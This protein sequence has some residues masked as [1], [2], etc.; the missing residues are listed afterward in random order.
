MSIYQKCKPN[1]EP[2]RSMHNYHQIL[3]LLRRYSRLVATIVIVAI[4]G[5]AVEGLGIGLVL[6]L[7][8]DGQQ[9]GELLQN[10]PLMGALSDF[11]GSL[12]LLNRLRFVAVAL[13]GIVVVQALMNYVDNLLVLRLKIRAEQQ[14]KQ[15]AYRQLHRVSIQFINQQ[16]AGDLLATVTRHTQQVSTIVSEVAGAVSNVAILA[17]YGLLMLLIS[18]QMTLV[19]MG[20]LLV[21]SLLSPKGTAERLHKAGE[22]TRAHIQEMYKVTFESLWIMKLIRLYSQETQRIDKFDKALQAY[23]ENHYLSQKLIFQTGPLYNVRV[24]LGLS[25]LLIIG[26]FLLP[27]Q[28]ESWMGQMGIFI[29]IVFRLMGPAAQLS[30]A[31]AQVTANVPSI[32]AVMDLLAEDDK[33]YLEDGTLTLEAIQ[34]GVCFDD[35]S[36]Q[37]KPDEAAVLDYVSF[38]IPQG[39]MTA[40]VGPSGAGKST[41]VDLVARLH[42]CTSGRITVDNVDIRHLKIAN[43]HAKIAVVSQDALLFWDSVIENIRFVRPTATAVEVVEAAKQAQIHDFILTLPE[44]YDTKLGD[45]GVRLSGGQQQR[46]AIARALLVNPQL[47][48]LDEA[49]SDLDSETERSIQ[50]AI[51]DYSQGRTLLV[52]AHRLSTIRHAHNI[53]VLDEGQVVEQGTHEELMQAYG[54]YWQLVQAQNLDRVPA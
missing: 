27:A 5:A 18:W 19:A 33:S 40:V 24:V 50:M 20:F 30:R 6:P 13:V 45:R 14:L 52:I 8:D 37:Y 26:T 21:L 39:R 4:A 10:V 46:I 53:V 12:T 11:L 31:R 36:F 47:L 43:W 34:D 32:Q 35:A 42:D 2:P 41:I 44:G 49:T 38:A 17:V 54:L 29:V 1:F 51:D 25:L 22:A 7:L 9:Q 15:D 23:V 16:R 3:A 48:I 28:T